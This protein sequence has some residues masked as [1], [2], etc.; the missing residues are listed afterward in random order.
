M[1]NAKE[2]FERWWKP[3]GEN[4]HNLRDMKLAKA[5]MEIGFDAGYS[6]ASLEWTSEPGWY[7]ERSKRFDNKP[8]ITEVREYK[9]L[10]VGNCPIAGWTDSEWA[11]PIPLPTERNN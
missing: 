11:G 10:C 5:E 1:T 6:A 3:I 7:W 4:Y 2:A 9:G 8:Q